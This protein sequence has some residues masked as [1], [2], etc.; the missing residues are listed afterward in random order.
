MTLTPTNLLCVLTVA[1]A[2]SCQAQERLFVAV[3]YM[4]LSD[5]SNERAYIELEK[6]WQRIHQKAVDGGRCRGW[7]LDRIEND[8]RNQFVTIR[9]YDAAKNLFEP[10]PGPLPTL[11]KDHFSTEEAAIM[12]KTE[13]IRQLTRSEVWEVE[14]SAMKSSEEVADYIRVDYMKVAP[15][16]MEAYYQAEKEVWRKAHQSRIDSGAMMV[17]FFLSRWFPSGTDMEYDFVTVNGYAS[18]AAW[19]KP[20]DVDKIQA[21]L[22]KEEL[23]KGA[24]TLGMRSAV[25]SE[26][27]RPVLRTK[28]PAK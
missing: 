17:W 3:D 7:Y 5:S 27:W 8:S 18:K 12:E 2:L 4:H 26:I 23:A 9:V 6:L 19:E 21:A 28:P 11:I 14:A 10:W 25:R 13:Q 15:G 22:T 24:E 20:W 16:K 1:A